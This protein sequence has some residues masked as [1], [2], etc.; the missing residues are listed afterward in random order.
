[1]HLLRLKSAVRQAIA[2]ALACALSV[3][4]WAQD[5]SSSAASTPPSAPQPQQFVLK[6]YAKPRSHFPN[7]FGPYL[8]QH[9]APPDLR[10]TPRIEQLMQNGKLMLS[11]DDAV[12]LAL[13]NNLDIAIARYNLN[14]ADTDILRTR[15]GAAGLGSPAGLVAGTLSGSQATLSTGGGPGGTSA[16]SGGAGSGLGGITF[17]TAGAGPPPEALEP[18][19]S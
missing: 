12:A 11:I 9:A 15:T 17:T 10:N 2:V 18:K 4:A 8:P 13:E 6:D 14:I 3:A 1:M 16:G 5:S 7:P 19:P